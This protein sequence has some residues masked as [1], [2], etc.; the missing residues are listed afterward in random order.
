MSFLCILNRKCLMIA[1]IL[2]FYFAKSITLNLLL[3]IHRHCFK[4]KYWISHFIF[5]TAMFKLFVTLFVINF[6]CF[7]G[8][9]ILIHCF[10]HHYIYTNKLLL[11]NADFCQLSQKRLFFSS[12]VSFFL[13]KNKSL[14]ICRNCASSIEVICCQYFQIFLFN[15]PNY[16]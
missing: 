13:M 11:S 8:V 4:L 9:F 15:F 6:H 5:T 10:L 14:S 16:F 7:A 3:R 1:T 2:L 12:E